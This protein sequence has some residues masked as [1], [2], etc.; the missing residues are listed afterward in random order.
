MAELKVL[1]PQKEVRVVFPQ[2][3]GRGIVAN[4]AHKQFEV[5]LQDYVG[6]GISYND[7]KLNV[8]PF[9]PTEIN[10]KL[11]NHEG[12]IADLEAK[13]D[14]FVKDVKATREGNKITLTY[15]Y[16]DGT[17]TAVDFDDNDTIAVEFDPT[18]IH[19]RL[20]RLEDKQPKQD[21]KIDE[22]AKHKV[23]SFAQNPAGDKY[24]ITLVNGET[25][26]APIT[27][28]EA[29]TVKFVNA[30]GDELVTVVQGEKSLEPTLEPTLEPQDE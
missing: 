26:E 20:D 16:T 8:T 4:H 17:S 1:A 21:D 12:R 30:W 24:I 18:A 22:I 7:G 28:V 9:D 29:Q 19:N 6:E 11:D 2:D 25:F 10:A 14:K 27:Q 15:N 23:K 3:L 13:E 5:D